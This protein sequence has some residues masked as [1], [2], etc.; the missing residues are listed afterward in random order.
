M[1]RT[2]NLD[3]GLLK[4]LQGIKN[5]QRLP[6][7]NL[8]VP[9]KF[10]GFSITQACTCEL[11]VSLLP[12]PVVVLSCPVL[13]TVL[14]WGGVKHHQDMRQDVLHKKRLNSAISFKSNCRQSKDIYPC[15]DESTIKNDTTLYDL[16][17]RTALTHGKQKFSTRS[18][19]TIQYFFAL[20]HLH[21]R[22]A[23]QSTCW[24]Q[25]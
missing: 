23:K 20:F 6:P 9:T 19:R 8:N 12:T 18:Q 17:T 15:L 25:K 21:P 7:C 5:E 10:Q 2:V 16:S 4:K 3:F 11:L 14:F 22:V 13:S 24:H 1:T